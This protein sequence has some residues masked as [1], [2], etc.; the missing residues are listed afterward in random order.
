VVETSKSD[1]G[2]T[3]SNRLNPE[4]EKEVKVLLKDHS[5]REIVAK[6]GVAH[7]TILRIRN[8]NFTK[9]EKAELKKRA[10]VK[11]RN[12]R[13]LEKRE[14]GADLQNDGQNIPSTDRDG[15]GGQEI[16]EKETKVCTK[17][18]GPPKPISEFNKNAARPDG[19]ES[20]CRSCTAQ[21]HRDWVTNRKKSAGGNGRK[22][23]K[24]RG[25]WP[26]R[27]LSAPTIPSEAVTLDAQLLRAVKKSA[28]L[29]FVKNDLP[30]IVEEA[31]A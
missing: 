27:S 23:R 1:D 13:E 20:R 5:I 4:K 28:I 15:K 10:N 17:C 7:N 21:A 6:T 9:E 14:L 16:M 25:P 29:D 12:R 31:F 11:G 18:G 3:M 2:E 30:R 8:E 26:G 22:K 19:H 24:A